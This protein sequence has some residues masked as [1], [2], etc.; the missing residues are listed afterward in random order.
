MRS[1]FTFIIATLILTA[2]SQT[3]ITST[4]LP[5]T[6]LTSST[7]PLSTPTLQ[8]TETPTPSPQSLLPQGVKEK[9]DQAGIDLKD[10]TNAKYDKDGLS[11]T[12]ES[13]EVI[14][15]MNDELKK[16]IYLGQDNVLQ[17]RDEANQNVV[18]AFDLETGKWAM[19]PEGQLSLDLDRWG[20]TPDKY[21]V[22]YDKDG[23]I[24]LR[25]KGTNKLIYWDGKWS[26]DV[27]VDMVVATNNC[28]P[29]KFP[30]APGINSPPREMNEEWNV[31]LN[32]VMQK[33]VFSPLV[34]T[35]A[36]VRA[37]FVYLPGTDNCW[38]VEINQYVKGRKHLFWM[39]REGE[40]QNLEYFDAKEYN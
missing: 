8:P 32:I 14:V 28:Q 21:N 24:E 38:G 6:T 7:A 20:L 10:M 15:L 12:L 22:G 39:D 13:G 18:Y 30:Q 3:S 9:F 5:S 11:I 33:I 35:M 1:I 40:L 19:T 17:Y 26:S 16:N 31:H 4:P 25:E 29:T 37:M 36:N 34:K 27:M 2:C 23:K